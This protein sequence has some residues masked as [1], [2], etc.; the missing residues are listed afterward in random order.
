VVDPLGRHG[1][2]EGMGRDGGHVIAVDGV[3][4]GDGFEELQLLLDEQ[5][6]DFSQETQ[7]AGGILE[8]L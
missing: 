1:V 3:A 8:H 4:S 2:G 6:V 5:A 7:T